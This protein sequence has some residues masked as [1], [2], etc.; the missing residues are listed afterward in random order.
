MAKPRQEAIRSLLHRTPSEKQKDALPF[1]LARANDSFCLSATLLSPA[2]SPRHRHRQTKLEARQGTLASSIDLASL[3]SGLGDFSSISIP[4]VGGIDPSLFESFSN[5]AQFTS[6][7][8]SIFSQIQSIYSANPGLVSSVINAQSSELA[9]AV[10]SSSAAAIVSQANSI[11]T[12]S[13]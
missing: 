13:A 9:A 7:N 10:G 2:L 5:I 12:A 3:T 6:Q 4:A 11:L 1:R 8:P